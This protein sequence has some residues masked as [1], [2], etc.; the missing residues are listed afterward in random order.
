MAGRGGGNH[1]ATI[2][3]RERPLPDVIEL[4]EK[5]HREVEQLFS[6]FESTRDLS[7]PSEICDE[8]DRHAAG[9]EQVVYPAIEAEV[10]SGKQ[11]VQEGVEEHRRRVS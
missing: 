2:T 5:D 9:E 1:E 6:K 11:F 7:I 3:R 10:P 8:L 4:I